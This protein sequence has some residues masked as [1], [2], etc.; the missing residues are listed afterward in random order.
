MNGAE[1]NVKPT[2]KI[3]VSCV[4]KAQYS[5]EDLGSLIITNQNPG[6]TNLL[7]INPYK[8]KL[9]AIPWKLPILSIPSCE[10]RQVVHLK[11]GIL[12]KWGFEEIE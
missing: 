11:L 8:L 4:S 6:K 1:I 7:G 12:V 5:T 10:T 9:P 2:S 3:D